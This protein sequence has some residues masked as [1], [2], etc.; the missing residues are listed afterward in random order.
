MGRYTHTPA[1]TSPSATRCRGSYP[2]P[3]N[4]LA[5]CAASA[6]SRKGPTL[7]H[8]LTSVNSPS[9]AESGAAAVLGER[10][11]VHTTIVAVSSLLLGVAVVQWTFGA[12]A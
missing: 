12:L 6:T 5:A 11:W 9:G 4:V 10:P 8:R 1:H 2:P 3:R 7:M